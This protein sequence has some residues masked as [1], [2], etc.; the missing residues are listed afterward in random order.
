MT[1]EQRFKRWFVHNSPPSWHVQCIES[2]TG[3]GIPDVNLC[4]HGLEIWLELKAGTPQ[5]KLRPEQLAWLTRRNTAG[6]R[7]YVLHQPKDDNHP[8]AIYSAPFVKTRVAGGYVIIEDTPLLW[9][10]GMPQLIE[11]L[12]L[13]PL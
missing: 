3:N 1:P 6:G 10:A 7:A 13:P 11:R 9:G 5:P 4:A 8:W 12:F 2:S